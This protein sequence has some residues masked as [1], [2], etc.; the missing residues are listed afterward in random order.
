GKHP[1]SFWMGTEGWAALLDD[2]D[3]GLGLVTPGRVHFTGGFAGQPGPNDT[4]GNSTGYLAGQG[5]EILDHDIIYE[6]RYE[7]VLG[8][9]SEIRARAAHHRSTALPAWNFAEDR[10]SWHYQNASDRGWP[11]QDYLEVTFDQN[12]PQLIS[13][14]TFWQAEEAPF[15]VIEA[16]FSTSQKQ[17]VVMWQALDEKGFSSD[18]FATFPI[19]GDGEFHRIVIRLAEHAGYRGALTRLR[20]D[21]V[22]QAEPGAWM[23]LRSLRLSVAEP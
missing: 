14:F 15:L 21:P 18:H 5:Q 10:R 23:K 3:F 8:A 19:Q 1:W 9:L 20:I 12:D 22:G 7:L 2:K 13:P 4:T 17:G 6:F 11:V 16:A